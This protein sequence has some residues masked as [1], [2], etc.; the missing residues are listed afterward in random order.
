MA[1]SIILLTK[2][3][4]QQEHIVKI[5]IFKIVYL[6]KNSFLFWAQGKL[7]RVNHNIPSCVAHREDIMNLYKLYH[8]FLVH[9]KK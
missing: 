4:D 8:T 7:I 3:P 6:S 2:L 9:R 1:Y 5:R